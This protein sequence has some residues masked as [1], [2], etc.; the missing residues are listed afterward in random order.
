MKKKTRIILVISLIVVCSVSFAYAIYWAFFDIQRI[1]GQ[2]VISESISPNKAYTVTA[3]L[4]NGG[5]TVDYAVLATVVNNSSEKSK[6]IYWQ[7]HCENVDIT[8]INN[9]TVCINGVTLNV[10]KD[11]Y[12]YRNTKY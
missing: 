2:D 6:N 8:W 12:D 10:I 1:H 4:N 9:E 11:T 5:A 7:Y 3:Y